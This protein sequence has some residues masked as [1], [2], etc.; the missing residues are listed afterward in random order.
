VSGHPCEAVP[1]SDVV[2]VGSGE[3][4]LDELDD[5]VAVV[6]GSVAAVGP[7]PAGSLESLH[8]AAHPTSHIGSL[9]DSPAN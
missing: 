8:A 2:E 4:G 7:E 5:V 3:V 9:L 6:G 1:V